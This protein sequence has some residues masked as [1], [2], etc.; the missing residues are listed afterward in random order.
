[1]KPYE[2]CQW[3][4]YWN[5][6]QY[7][8]FVDD[9]A[10]ADEPRRRRETAYGRFDCRKRSPVYENVAGKSA[11][12]PQTEGREWCGDFENFQVDK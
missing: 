12:W 4:R 6:F 1:M 5:I 7:I 10:L 2:K 3:C 8:S 9:E 11:Q